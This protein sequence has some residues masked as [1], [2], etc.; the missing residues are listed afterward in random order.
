MPD[1]LRCLIHFSTSV[2]SQATLLLLNAIR[3]GKSPRFSISKMVRQDA[4]LQ[5]GHFN[6]FI[7][8]LTLRAGL[9]GALQANNS[10]LDEEK[11]SEEVFKS[12]GFSNIDEATLA[13]YLKTPKLMGL[14]R[15][16]AQR[17]LRYIIGYRLIRD[18][19]RGWR[20]N[21]PNLDQLSLLK[22]GYRGLDGFCSEDD[23]FSGSKNSVLSKLNAFNRANLCRVLFDEMRTALCLETRYLDS[24]EQDKARNSA[25]TYL[26]ERWA[27]APDEK[28]ETSK[29]LILTKRPEYRGK[30]RTD[31]V[32]GCCDQLIE[33]VKKKLG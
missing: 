21:N 12:L 7:F 10:L 15:Q 2:K 28:L 14:A 24:V 1:S 11:L 29:F 18:L 33:T 8:L 32:S 19:R 16:E 25:F 23:L 4:A 20:F 13:E 27:F 9:I 5:A 3:R 6:D 22:I 26:N 31:L 17:T 30:P